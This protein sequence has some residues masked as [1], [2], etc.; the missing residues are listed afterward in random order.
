MLDYL[1]LSDKNLAQMTVKALP[2]QINPAAA[3]VSFLVVFSFSFPS[4]RAVLPL[5]VSFLDFKM[6]ASQIPTAPFSG[7][8]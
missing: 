1:L 5:P 3:I 6:L 7:F 2:G 8:V 4:F